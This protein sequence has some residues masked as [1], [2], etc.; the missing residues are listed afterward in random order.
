VLISV[1]VLVVTNDRAGHVYTEQNITQSEFIAVHSIVRP[2]DVSDWTR[3][4]WIEVTKTTE[5]LPG[6]V[7]K[8]RTLYTVSQ[9]SID[10][11]NRSVEV[12]TFDD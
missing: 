12:E 9:A 8:H 5:P 4:T 1:C 10:R 6:N 3:H 2:V 7:N 11:L